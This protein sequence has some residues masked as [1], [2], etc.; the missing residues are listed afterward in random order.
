MA[1]MTEAK[2][3]RIEAANCR[4]LA[5]TIKNDQGRRKLIPLADGY[6]AQAA[7]LEVPQPV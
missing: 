5:E 4:R 2:P 1:Q 6:E 7:T 3:L